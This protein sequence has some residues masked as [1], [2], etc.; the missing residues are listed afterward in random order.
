MRICLHIRAN[1][2]R[3][4]R[5]SRKARHSTRCLQNQMLLITEQRSYYGHEHSAVD[6]IDAA[7]SNNQRI[8]LHISRCMHATI[9]HTAR[10]NRAS[11][12]HARSATSGHTLPQSH[13]C[14]WPQVTEPRVVTQPQLRAASG[15]TNRHRATS[16][17]RPNA[18]SPSHD[19]TE[20]HNH[21]AN[22][23]ADPH[24]HRAT[25][26]S[27]TT[28]H[29]HR[30]TSGRIS[31]RSQSHRSTITESREVHTITE[32]R[33]VAEPHDHRATSGPKS[34]RSQSHE[35]SQNHECYRGCR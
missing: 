30:A 6:P 4:L 34:T 24:R 14:T 5:A 25:S 26:G 21:R 7:T 11:H 16:G 32:P 19:V 23:V 13:E 29:G 27:T 3:M 2:H 28:W 33:V 8:G 10:N 15:H 12:A 17:R 9:R 1:T 22:V 20:L 31:T 35:C 18:W